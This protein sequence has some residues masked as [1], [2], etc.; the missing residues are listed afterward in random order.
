MKNH[1]YKSVARIALPVALQSLLQSSFSVIDQLMIGQLGSQNI[2]G[3]GLGGKFASLYSVLLGAV[4]T[5][6]GIMIS[7]YAGQKNE[8]ETGRSFFVNTGLAVGIALFFFFVCVCFPENIMRLYTRDAGTGKLAEE[9]LRIYAFSYLPMAL[10]SITSV[11]LRCIEA[12]ALPLYASLASVLL[13]TGLNYLLIFGK[14]GFPMLG[15]KGAAL[16]TAISQFGACVLILFLFTRQYR[17]Q[18]MHFSFLWRLDR[19]NWIQYL[20]ILCPLLV[21]EF[22]WSLG[23]N[24]YTAI[25]GNMGTDPCAAMTLT[26]PIQTLLVG[27][28]SGISQAA[29]I[30]IGK[31]LGRREYDS[32]QKESVE[33]MLLGFGGSLVLSLILIGARNFYVGIF[34]V[35]DDVQEL[36]CQILLAFALIAP[37]KVQNMILGG[38]IIRSGGKTKYV[39]WIDLIGTWFAGVPLGLLAAFVWNLSIPYVYFVL[40]LEECLRWGISMAVFKRG[41]WINSLEAVEEEKGDLSTVGTGPEYK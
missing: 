7:Q 37:V 22:L 16:A 34:R 38:G 8:R 30:L 3:V 12:A 32:A 6:A 25:Y 10:G 36:A 35:E 9:Y 27:T 2:A 33:L 26:I 15:I 17:K 4:A 31:T 23:E 29:G 14:G 18:D 40:S 1:F 13:N 20:G 41:I 19:A 28:L 24:V 11:L 5:A 39:M 21:C